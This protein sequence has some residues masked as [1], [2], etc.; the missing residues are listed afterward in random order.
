MFRDRE[1]RMF[2]RLFLD[3]PRAV[4]ETYGEHMGVAARFGAR[5][6]VAGAACL[7]HAFVP[8]LFTRIGSTAVK[9]LYGEMKS[10]QPTLSDRPPAYLSGEWQLEYEI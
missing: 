5:L 8:A 4:G 9:A 7:V 3:H 1:C 10:R 6:I 2:D